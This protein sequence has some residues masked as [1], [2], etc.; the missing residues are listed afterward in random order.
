MRASDEVATMP[1]ARSPPASLPSTSLFCSSSG[2]PSAAALNTSLASLCASCALLN[3]TISVPILMDLTMACSFS[4]I[5][6]GT[7]SCGVMP[8]CVHR[9]VK[10]RYI[11]KKSCTGENR[12]P[13]A[14]SDAA[15]SHRRRAP[16]TYALKV[17]KPIPQFV[18][19]QCLQTLSFLTSSSTVG[20]APPCTSTLYESRNPLWQAKCSGVWSPLNCASE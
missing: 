19:V 16:G 17:H 6:A 4:C 10:D 2:R 3:L 11:H 7:K 18:L 14:S 9:S 8:S 15:T 13:C 12:L 1:V 20:S 5:P